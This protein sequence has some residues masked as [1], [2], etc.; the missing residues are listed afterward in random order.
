VSDSTK[1]EERFNARKFAK[2]LCHDK[3][4]YVT[5][6]NCH[7]R[8]GWAPIFEKFIARVGRYSVLINIAVDHHEFMEIDVDMGRTTRARY[9]YQQI[10]IAKYESMKTCAHCG[11]TK[12]EDGNK[13]CKECNANAANLKTTGTWLDKF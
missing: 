11:S 13:F 6:S 4:I 9:I 12:S 7:F 1:P 3:Q 10:L 2:E 5:A 8:K